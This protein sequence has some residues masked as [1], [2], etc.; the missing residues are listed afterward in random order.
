MKKRLF[1]FGL[2]FLLTIVGC[3]CSVKK[4][5]IHETY[6]EENTQDGDLQILNENVLPQEEDIIDVITNMDTN[7]KYDNVEE[8]QD[9]ADIIVKGEVISTNSYVSEFCVLT[10]FQI[11]VEEA[12]KNA[13]V[14][15]VVTI[16]SAGGVVPY[17]EYQNSG[18]ENIKDFEKKIPVKNASKTK[19]RMYVGKNELITVGKE[20]VIFAKKEYI[21]DQN[22]SRK[23]EYCILNIDQGQFEIQ[24]K[25]TINKTLEQEFSL[26]EICEKIR[27]RK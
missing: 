9:V 4:E 5:S 6:D 23:E 13:Q 22:A 19:V 21:L 1:V 27:K 24:E 26:D 25:K 20:Y 16:I 3:G 2:F 15:D 10:E 14:G 11:V 18:E 12:F 7:V 17:S 8:M